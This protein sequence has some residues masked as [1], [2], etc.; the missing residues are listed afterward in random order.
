MKV[1]QL[2]AAAQAQR[3]SGNREAAE[4]TCRQILAQHPGQPETLNLMAML[5]HEAGWPD[6]AIAYLR[7]AL[8]GRPLDAAFHYNLGTILHQQDALDDAIACYRQALRLKPEL[9]EAL[10]NLGN[11]LRRRGDDDEA[12][13]IFEQVLKAQPQSAEAYNNV[14]TA[15]Y[16]LGRF[17]EAAAHFERAIELKPDHAKAHYNRALVW[18]LTGDLVRGWQ[19]YEWRWKRP[20]YAPPALP[21]PTWDG[22]PLDGKRI[23]LYAEQGLGDVLQFIRYAPLVADRG[24]N[25]VVACHRL[26]IPLLSRCGAI[27]E[28]TPLDAPPPECDAQAA[29]MS[30]PRLLG[31]SLAT[32]PAS[33]PYLLADP[34]LVVFWREKQRSIEGFKIGI[35]WQG[36]TRYENDRQRSIRLSFFEPVAALPGVQLISLQKGPGIEQLAT[37]RMSSAHQNPLSDAAVGTAHPTIVDL[38]D[39]MDTARGAFMDTA[40]IMQSL[41]LVITS[42]T[43]IAH[44]AGGLGVKVWV[45]LPKVPDWRWLL[46]RE[47]SPWYPTMHL[48]R[49]K[50]TGDWASAFRGIA[51]AVS[52]EM[53]AP[54]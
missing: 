49:Q 30:L 20:G 8:V 11:A 2:L 28:L 50:T 16:K 52:A 18:L 37:S 15:L 21:Q 48:F 22:S 54:G 43:A 3:R 39:D 47:D 4:Q 51:S 29:L 19:E 13:A 31:T 46:E 17:D 12:L 38:G 44:L 32:V 27:A 36:A 41:D 40:A 25:V 26:L 14:G 23:L 35:A 10:A 45:A 34:D 6:A 33:I 9:V 7:R 24:G 1:A 53:A 5:A 42:D